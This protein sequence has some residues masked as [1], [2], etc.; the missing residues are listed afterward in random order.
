V[1]NP[2]AA[3]AAPAI[4]PIIAWEELLGIPKY[5]V[6]KFHEIAAMRAANITNE[7]F[8]NVKGS[9]IPSVMVSATPVKVIAPIKFI[10]D[11]NKI[12]CLG[13][14]AFVETDVAIAFPVS[15]KPLIKAN[16]KE[17]ITIKMVR[18]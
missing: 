1:L 7:P 11:A 16:A 18:I 9:T 8:G 4:A 15:W 13:L 10:T 17:K 3:M 6:I 5:Q 14:R 12:A 2:V